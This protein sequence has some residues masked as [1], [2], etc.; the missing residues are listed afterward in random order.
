MTAK[1]KTTKKKTV[2]KKTAKKETPPPISDHVGSK[3]AEL[4]VIK[5]GEK[6]WDLKLKI[7]AINDSVK[8]LKKEKDEVADKLL[9]IMLRGNMEKFRVPDTADFSVK[10]TDHVSIV[11]GEEETLHT[12]L[13]QNGHGKMIHDTVNAAEVKDLYRELIAEAFLDGKHEELEAELTEELKCLRVYTDIGLSVR[14]VAVK[15][16]TY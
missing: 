15:K 10:P 7:D 3:K 4:I 13:K 14:K 9:S 1:K 11:K 2:K 16:K 6:Y 5:L 12:W 8:P